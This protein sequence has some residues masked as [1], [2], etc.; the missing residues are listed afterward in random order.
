MSDQVSDLS[1]I[2]SKENFNT[3]E[4]INSVLK[5]GQLN[6]KGDITNNNSV[7]IENS[8]ESV[9]T[10]LLSKLQIYAIELNM[11]LETITSESLLI[12]PKAIRE[13]DRVRKES[14]QLKSR[15]KFIYSKIA[16]LEQTPQSSETISLIT[17]LDMVKTRMEQSIRSLKEA[18]KLLHFSREVDK[19]F[20][21]TDYLMIADKLQEVKQSLLVL[22]DVPEFREQSKHFYQYQDRLENQMKPLLF[23]SLQC[24]D[25]SSTSNYL[26]VFQ[27]IQREDHF[28]QYYNQNRLEPIKSMWN[29]NTLP[30]NHFLSK[31][32]DEI[33]HCCE[34]ERNWLNNLFSSSS[35]K[36]S[37]NN[38]NIIT[39]LVDLICVLFQSIQQGFQSKIDLMIQSSQPGQ[40]IK[41]VELL[42]L[43][44]ITLQFLKSLGVVLGGSTE[45]ELQKYYKS[46]LEPF[47]YFQTKFSEFEHKQLVSNTTIITPLKKNDFQLILSNIDQLI[48]KVFIMCQNSLDRFFEFTHCIELDSYIQSLNKFFV[49]FGNQ[50]KE[51]L[52]ELKSTSI[53]T[54]TA[55]GDQLKQHQRSNST[56]GTSQQVNWEYFQGAMK[57]LQISNQLLNKFQKLDQTFN[58]SIQ[59]YLSNESNDLKVLLQDLN[60][61]NRLQK[62]IQSLSSINNN[63]S[64]TK[65]IYIL[66]ESYES[67][68]QFISSCQY[69]V[70]ETMIQFVKKILKELPKMSEWKLQSNSQNS[71]NSQLIQISYMT[72]ITD[73]LLTIPQQLHPYSEEDDIRLSLSIAKQFPITSDESYQSIID[74]YHQ[75]QQ[76]QQQQEQTLT[77]NSQQDQTNEEDN[78][79]YEGISHQ[80]IS[81][82]AKSTEKL[83]LQ[84]I[85]DI[86]QLSDMGSQQLSNDIGYLFNVFSALDVTP[87]TLLQKT[88]QFIT[89][90]RIKLQDLNQSLSGA[91][92]NISNLIIKMRSK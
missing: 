62:S 49:Y 33:I 25:L 78:D 50:L 40:P 12:V 2:F 91:E 64:N 72:Q 86:P 77:D 41:I 57:L 89:M 55:T 56:S 35:L 27:K 20:S 34:N 71:Q 92:K 59:H 26:Q 17:K 75:H 70:Y 63:N 36:N 74:H 14:L 76:Q 48:P 68:C 6:N 45:Q 43:Y 29:S 47:K 16:E 90:D 24:R 81:L 1:F 9:T 28:Y 66:Q 32:F 84:S 15:I 7:Q 61:L 87:D 60:K 8:L 46:I 53:N 38:N 44:K 54:T 13:I 21:S 37:N 42:Q 80:W 52:M 65:Q 11:S 18:E 69:F 4:W 58:S 88:Q 10:Q 39:I 67:I 51:S 85:V 5:V 23:Q 79:E 19:L 31:F 3:K 22:N 82:V 73:H 30:F 83:Y